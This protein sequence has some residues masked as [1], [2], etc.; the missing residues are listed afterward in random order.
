M[1]KFTQFNSKLK[2]EYFLLP[3]GILGRFFTIVS[4]FLYEV[5]NVSLRSVLVTIQT[6]LVPLRS[7]IK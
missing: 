5:V 6:V 2:T 1:Q 3:L 7:Q 4:T